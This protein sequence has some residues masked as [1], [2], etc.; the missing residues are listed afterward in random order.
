MDAAPSSPV[1]GPISVIVPLPDGKTY[2]GGRFTSVADVERPRFARLNSDGSLDL[3]FDPFRFN[4]FVQ[5]ISVQSDGKILVAGNF[6]SDFDGRNH[7]ARLNTDGSLDFTFDARLDRSFDGLSFVAA[8]PDGKIFVS[9]GALR[10]GVARLNSDGS[11]DTSFKPA[12]FARVLA[13]QPDDRLIVVA[14]RQTQS[15]LARLNKDGTVD[16]TFNDP[17]IRDG[18]TPGLV[19]GAILQPDSK[20]LVAGHFQLVSG[21]A[22]KGIVRLNEDGT[23]DE[24]FAAGNI[25]SCYALALQPDL[26]VLVTAGILTNGIGYDYMFR[27]NSNGTLDE[28]F[29]PRRAIGSLELSGIA[30]RSDGRVLVASGVEGWEGL[31]QLNTDGSTDITFAINNLFNFKPPTLSIERHGSQVR[32]IWSSAAYSLQSSSDPAGPF[33]VVVGA[34]TGSTN[35]PTE[36]R[37]F[38]R[39]A[40]NDPP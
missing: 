10:S 36:P 1:N 13:V 20:I 31:A 29:P 39:L 24:S 6:L 15:F 16:P 18:D 14:H 23:V 33:T 2:I 5:A 4:N 11:M 19:R 30:V 12:I 38:F 3:A 22:R 21:Q 8:K 7:L 37:I 40:A 26:K 25:E 28:D 32:L 35:T 27:L 17:Q 34:T 9:G